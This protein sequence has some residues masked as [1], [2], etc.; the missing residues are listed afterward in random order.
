MIQNIN[1]VTIKD[2]TRMM[3]TYE[4]IVSFYNNKYQFD[5]SKAP[6]KDQK[7]YSSA[8]NS[9][10]FMKSKRDQLKAA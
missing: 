7:K 6:A 9:W 8:L 3:R 10:D 5:I 2:I 4:R 1:G